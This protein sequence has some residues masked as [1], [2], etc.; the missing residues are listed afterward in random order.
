MTRAD[1]RGGGGGKTHAWRARSAACRRGG[2]AAGLRLGE[3]SGK[4]RRTA[5]T[6]AQARVRDG[7]PRS[8]R[9]LAGL[10]GTTGR[11]DP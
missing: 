4:G 3:E 1:L 5:H 8:A 10:Q 9:S 2:C 6:R 11:A 7:Y